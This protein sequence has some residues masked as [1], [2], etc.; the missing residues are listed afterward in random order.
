[1]A[2]T[3]I[4]TQSSHTQDRETLSLSK[5]RLP[6]LWWRNN[7]GGSGAVRAYQ[8]SWGPFSAVQQVVKVVE[9]LKRKGGGWSSEVPTHR[10]HLDERRSLG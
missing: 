10:H 5:A 2:V 3:K 4:S 9:L 1:M 8:C 6:V 7:R